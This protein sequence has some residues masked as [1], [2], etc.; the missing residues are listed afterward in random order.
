MQ[1]NGSFQIVTDV[2]SVIPTF[3]SCIALFIFLGGGGIKFAATVK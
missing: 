2:T 3:L 1:I